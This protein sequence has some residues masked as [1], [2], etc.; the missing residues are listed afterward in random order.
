[1]KLTQATA[2][3]LTLQSFVNPRP[4][5]LG[6]V[7][8]KLVVS[9]GFSLNTQALTWMFLHNQPCRGSGHP[10]RLA[11]GKLVMREQRHV[12]DTRT[13]RLLSE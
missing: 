2:E 13:V 6:Y 11:M 1:M 3:P 9:S 4:I 7:K 5:S 10:C 12:R 8:M